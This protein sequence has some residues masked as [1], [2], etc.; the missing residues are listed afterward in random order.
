MKT[1]YILFISLAVK[2]YAEC[3]SEELGYPCCSKYIREPS[4]INDEGKWGLENG[5]W[6]EID[7]CWARESGYDCCSEDNQKVIYTDEMGSWGYE[8]DNWCGIIVKKQEEEEQQPIKSS[9]TIPREKCPFYTYSPEQCTRQGGVA[10]IVTKNGCPTPTCV[11]EQLPTEASQPVPEETNNNVVAAA[12]E[13]WAKEFG[14]NCCS[15]DN[16]NVIYT[17]EM[18][19]WG[20][21]NDN[22]CGIVKVQEEEVQEE[23]IQEEEPIKS[24]K[25]IPRQNCPFYTY[26]PEQCTRQGGVASIV[27]KNGCPTPT[28]VIEQLPTEASQPEPEET[29]NNAVAAADECWAKE[30]GYNCCSKDN[31]NVIYTEDMYS[32]GY[33]KDEWCGIVKVQ[34]EEVQEE[35]PIKSTKTI[36]RQNCPYYTYS[37]EQCTREGGVASI[38]T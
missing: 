7:E 2:A 24:T 6:C 12:D 13:C 16:Q 15:K 23:E 28:C 20:Y 5:N 14:Y 30:F 36:P 34:E 27:T 22:W 25:T 31:Q 9:K 19:S 10:S 33:E 37:P 38:V 32:W 8:N 26:S 1:L 3:W 21:E 29:N 18:Y 17:E 4:Y 35:E 11:I